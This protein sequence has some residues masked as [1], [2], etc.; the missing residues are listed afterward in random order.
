MLP[1]KS[2]ARQRLETY[3][4]VSRT[5]TDE[6]TYGLEHTVVGSVLAGVTADR[7]GQCGAYDRVVVPVDVGD[8]ETDDMGLTLL[9]RWDDSHTE[10]MRWK[11]EEIRRAIAIA[12]AVMEDIEWAGDIGDM[13]K[14]KIMRRADELLQ[15]EK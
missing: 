10:T 8:R 9:E 2:T 1:I 13:D 4:S 11:P 12:Q 5:Q 7:C 6:E 14:Q 15:G 3:A